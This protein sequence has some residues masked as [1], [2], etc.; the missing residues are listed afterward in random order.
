MNK[1]KKPNIPAVFKMR[2]LI[3]EQQGAEKIAKENGHDLTFWRHS[4][5]FEHIS[6]AY[7]KKCQREIV[8]GLPLESPIGRAL[9]EKCEDTEHCTTTI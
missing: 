7:C 6:I 5:V 3:K 2:E 9:K 8:C 1:N 4:C